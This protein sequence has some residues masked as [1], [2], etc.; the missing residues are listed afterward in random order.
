MTSIGEMLGEQADKLVQDNIKI[1]DVHYINLDGGNGI[2]PKN[3]DISRDK[4]FIV[5]GFD[6][7]GNVIGGV[8]INS[9]INYN[10]P[11]SITDYQLPVKVKQFP[12]LR[13]NSFI[14]CS[15]LVI[16]SRAKFSMSTYRGE[17]SDKDTLELIVGTVR[18][19]PMINKKQLKEFRII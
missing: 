11:A 9:N 10:L 3:G 7:K 15:N 1:G 14:N 2:T 4:F 17:V 18:E 5:L 12:F 19:S 16:A 13:Y 8:V 6:D